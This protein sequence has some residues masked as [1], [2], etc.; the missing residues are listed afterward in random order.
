MTHHSQSVHSYC[1]SGFQKSLFPPLLSLCALI[2]V[3]FWRIGRCVTTH[4]HTQTHTHM[5]PL[6]WLLQLIRIPNTNKKGTKWT[7]SCAGCLSL[8][9]LSLSSLSSLS[10]LSLSWH[11]HQSGEE[12]GLRFCHL[13]REIINENLDQNVTRNQ[14][15]KPLSCSHVGD[16]SF[17]VVRAFQRRRG[18]GGKAKMVWSGQKKREWEGVGEGEWVSEWVVTKMPLVSME[19]KNYNNN[20][21]NQCWEWVWDSKEKP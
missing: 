16:L 4:R 2:V 11:H 9:S 12:F 21:N 10:T 19:K 1:L 15:G 8:T 20:N 17:F 3:F 6:L 18:E 14:N 7:G 13:P 5:W